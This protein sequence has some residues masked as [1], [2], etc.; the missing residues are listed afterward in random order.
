MIK[1][2]SMRSDADSQLTALLAAEGV[3][4]LTSK[5][6]QGP[7]GH[8]RRRFIR[9]FSIDELPQLLNVSRAT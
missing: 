3:A 1:F 2:R 4:V 5:M 8:A 9:R 7:A 6:T